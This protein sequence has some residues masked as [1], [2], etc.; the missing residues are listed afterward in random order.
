MMCV[1]FQCRT[2]GT[3]RGQGAVTVQTNHIGRFSQFCVI[4]RSVNIVATGAGN[5]VL[6][7][8]TLHKVV[9]LHPVLVRRAVR[10]IVEGQLSQRVILQLPE[11]LELAGPSGSRPASRNI[12]LG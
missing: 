9:A 8:D 5:S 1:L 4:V 3:V 10:E 2:T 7:H 6:V 12:G 11:V